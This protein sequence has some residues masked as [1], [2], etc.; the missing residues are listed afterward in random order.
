M[1]KTKELILNNKIVFKVSNLN[2][3]KILNYPYLNNKIS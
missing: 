3:E 1:A 2:E